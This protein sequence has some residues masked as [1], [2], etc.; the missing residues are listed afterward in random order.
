MT[1][2]LAVALVFLF[3]GSAGASTPSNRFGVQDDAWLRWGLGTKNP[4]TLESRLNLLDTLGVKLVRF[5]LVWRQVAPTE[6]RDP[7]NPNDPAYD[8][9]AFDPVMRGLHAHRITTLVT[10]WA[11]PAWA[12]GGHGQNF[13]PTRGMGNF[14]YAAARRYPWVR[15]W[16]A[17]N[18]PNLRTFAVPVSP[19]NYVRHVLNPAWSWLHR[20][21]RANRVAGGVTS[22]RGTPS[23]MGPVAFA[24]GMRRAHARL[25]AYAANPHPVSR[26]ETPFGDPCRHCRTLTM[27][28]LGMIRRL[29][30]RL[31]GA[32]TPLWL[33]EY[34]VE[35]NPPQR[36]RGV[37]WPRQALFVSR[38]ALRVWQQPN[39]TL[40]IWF[41]VRDEPKVARWQSGLF[42]TNGVP[43]PARAA[44]AL[45]LAQISRHRTR[46]VLWG[47]VRPGT[48]R[49]PYA[50]QR[51]RN[52]RWVNVV[53]RLR[54]GVGGTFRVTV[55]LARGT[56]VR[57]RSS[58]APWPSP[59]LVVR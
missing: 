51:I 34:A 52:A 22:P 5:T 15:L 1:A 11:S 49:R 25:D 8:W 17:W 44:F 57:L 29:V 21:N 41:L 28:R 32:R 9:H 18:E 58:R 33:T 39:S 10:I 3:V 54:T 30:T 43:K 48:G 7:T 13:M 2:A 50:I 16:T 20:A 38:S 55:N 36:A 47:Q 40:L 23:G 46:T 24:E 19:A 35:T 26:N 59:V 42:T 6:P 12:N 45:P 27:A 56:R 37:P 53:W 31:W 14:A 4:G